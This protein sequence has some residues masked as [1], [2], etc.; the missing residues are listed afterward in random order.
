M[1]WAIAG[2]LED[3]PLLDA[4]LHSMRFD[5]QVDDSR[6]EWLWQLMQTVHAEDRF[7][8][9][10]L[11]AMHNFSDGWTTEQ[12][13]ELG[14]HYATSGDEAFR[15]RLYGIVEERP[16]ADMPWLGEEQIV[17]LDGEQGFLFAARLRG[18]RLETQEFDWDDNNLL[19]VAIERLGEDRVI[20]SLEAATDGAT[21]R[22][23]DGWCWHKD[24]QASEKRIPHSER[25][26]QIPISKII[27]NAESGEL[28][29]GVARGWGM[30]ATERD[31]E[32]IR[33][34]LLAAS[35][36]SVVA[37]YLK[38]FSNREFLPL[39]SDL[40]EFCRHSD[41]EVRRRAFAALEKNADSAVRQFAIDQLRESSGDRSAIS[42]FTKNY[43]QGDEQR[44]LEYIEPPD[45]KNELHWMLMN[46]TEVLENN[47]QADCSQL[48][49]LAYAL[50]PCGTC[51]Y[52]AA[53]L[54]H[55]RDVVPSWLTA[56]CRFDAES[57]TRQLADE[58]PPS[59]STKAVGSA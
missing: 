54:L 40:L 20:A 42:L 22:F 50:T 36:P 31:L 51:R 1:Q 45:D 49:V 12:L 27:S 16:V 17:Q 6:G 57:D 18:K 4:C 53:R 39:V 58:G 7:R 55:A 2:R 15:A 46:V 10:I 37:R 34:R 11:D 23:R 30:Y 5:A 38:V 8:S 28:S 47:P 26:R 52:H 9:T 59:G 29:I 25:M 3:E 41:D 56:E 14:F 48:G 44:I 43:Q 21:Q 19:N 33:Q 24:R 13:C 32:I 35:T